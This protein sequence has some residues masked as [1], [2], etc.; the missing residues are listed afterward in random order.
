MCKPEDRPIVEASTNVKKQPCRVDEKP[1]ERGGISGRILEWC[2]LADPA[3]GLKRV[4]HSYPSNQEGGGSRVSRR[5]A[6]RERQGP[7]S[8]RFGASF[9]LRDGSSATGAKFGTLRQAEGWQKG[10]QHARKLQLRTCDLRCGK[11][12]PAGRF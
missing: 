9:G 10:S 4:G 11:A 2:L 3:A 6:R 8:P 7:L 12:Q 5:G 1:V